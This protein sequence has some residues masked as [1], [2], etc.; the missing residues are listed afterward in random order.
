MFDEK[1][2]EQVVEETLE[3]S[4]IQNVEKAS[5]EDASTTTADNVAEIADYLN[6]ELF[7]DVKTLSVSDLDENANST[8]PSDEI[9]K[10][11]MYTFHINYLFI[12]FPE[13]LPYCGMYC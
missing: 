7:N 9:E 12:K 3:A 13:N 2:Q 8:D 6:P 1:N 4:E 5:A 10:K 11:Y